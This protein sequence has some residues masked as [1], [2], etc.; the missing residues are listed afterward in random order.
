MALHARSQDL[1]LDLITMFEEFLNHIVAE[2]VLH[3]LHQVRKEFFENAGFLVA[4]CC[5]KLLLDEAGTM[6]I[7]TELDHIAIDVLGG[8]V[9]DHDARHPAMIDGYLL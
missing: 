2:N 3:E 1:L 4:V 8:M 5:L 6:L 7:A 9:S